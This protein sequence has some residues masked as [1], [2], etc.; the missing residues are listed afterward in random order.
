MVQLPPNVFQSQVVYNRGRKTWL[1][2]QLYRK[3]E[4]KVQKLYNEFEY[5][6]MWLILDY[7]KLF[8]YMKDTLISPPFKCFLDISDIFF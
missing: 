2:E 4:W 7:G 6:E 8:V 5:V 3:T 1:C